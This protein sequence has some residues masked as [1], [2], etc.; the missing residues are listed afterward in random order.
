MFLDRKLKHHQ[1]LT[2]EKPNAMR[3]QFEHCL[4]KSLKHLAQETGILKRDHESCYEM[5]ETAASQND[6][7]TLF[8]AT[9]FSSQ[10]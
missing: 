10:T 8:A 2:E 1:V 3:A 4:V 7:C 6:T 5:I 9:R